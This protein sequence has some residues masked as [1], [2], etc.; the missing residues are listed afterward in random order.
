[1]NDLVRKLGQEKIKIFDKDPDYFID[2]YRDKAISQGYKGDLK[3]KKEGPNIIIFV[4]II[5]SEDNNSF[6]CI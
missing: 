2:Y 5:D 4:K 6:E 3:F 1:M